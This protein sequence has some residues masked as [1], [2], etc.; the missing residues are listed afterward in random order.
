M[1]G[2]DVTSE[3]SAIAAFAT[4][5]VVAVD[6]AEMRKAIAALL[7]ML[8]YMFVCCV[9]VYVSVLDLLYICSILVIS[10]IASYGAYLG[11]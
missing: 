1:I 8:F 7:N 9:V 4:M 2:S 10:T 11:N 3:K 5:D 6:A